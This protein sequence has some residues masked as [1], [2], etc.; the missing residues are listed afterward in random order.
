MTF[1]LP[2]ALLG[3]LLVP[4]A[5]GLY[6]LA[7]R[8]RSAYTIRFTN[9]ALLGQVAPRRPGARRH[10]PAGL[11]L[12]AL[13]ALVVSFSRPQAVITIPKDRSQVMLVIDTSGSMQATDVQPTRLDAAR[14]AAHSLIDSLP[15]N[16][17]VGLIGFSATAYVVAPLTGDHGAVID[18]LQYLQARGGTAIGD[19]LNLA[20]D[21]L[22]VT[23]SGPQSRPPS[24]VVLL[25]DGVSNAGSA[26]QDAA[27]RAAAA[28][29]PVETIG[30]GTRNGGVFV[31][32]Q[33]V[34][35][36]DEQALQAIA[37]TTS[38]KYFFAVDTSQLQ[39]IYSTLG[40]QF[41]WRQQRV[42]LTVPMVLGGTLILVAGAALSLRWFR[43]L[44]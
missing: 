34:G 15:G 37:Q 16:A 1:G 44:P 19:G 9:L 4:V 12:L 27:D 18:S 36:V 39:S 25:T 17:S 10:I 7:Q 23:A 26:P 21:Q 8:R 43:L 13:T 35:G 31:R 42:D 3:L 11:F 32:G 20:L 5:V 6:W 14:N 33:D 38:G 41:G 22:G 40:G 28:H 30:V 29:I 2:I 24:M